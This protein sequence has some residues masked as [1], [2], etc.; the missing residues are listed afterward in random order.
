M[1]EVWFAVAW[2]LLLNTEKIYKDLLWPPVI[3]LAEK[4]GNS[5]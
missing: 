3:A 5:S 1:S 4:K 2:T